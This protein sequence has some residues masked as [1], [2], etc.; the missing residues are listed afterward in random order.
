MSGPSSYSDDEGDFDEEDEGERRA[1]VNCTAP[2]PSVDDAIC[3]DC[4]HSCSQ[5]AELFR[6]S[7]ADR[8]AWSRPQADPVALLYDERMELHEEGGCAPH[9]ERPDRI[10]AVMARLLASGL[11][12]A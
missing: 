6:A 5:D 9:P 11:A 8:P 4:G 12:G 2:L 3:E 7:P 1:C 10:R